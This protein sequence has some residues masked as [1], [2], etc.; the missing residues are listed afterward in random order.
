MKI[1]WEWTW[2]KYPGKSPVME[3]KMQPASNFS[4]CGKIGKWDTVSGVGTNVG[5]K[6]VGKFVENIG[7]F[8]GKFCCR[9][10]LGT[11]GRA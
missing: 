7:I 3:I 4:L 11:S 2:E 1:H 9:N 8:F 5:E 6:L 10:G